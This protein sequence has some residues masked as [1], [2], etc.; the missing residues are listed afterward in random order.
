M[1]LVFLEKI[2]YTQPTQINLEDK[3]REVRLAEV[4]LDEEEE[5]VDKVLE[6]G[7]PEVGDD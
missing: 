5:E 7:N 4:E 2:G 1:G 3:T 6:V